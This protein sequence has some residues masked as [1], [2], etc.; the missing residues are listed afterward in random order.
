MCVTTEDV[1]VLL[2]GIMGSVLA[3][4]GKEVWGPSAG[5]ILRA[6]KSRGESVRELEL[7]GDDPNLDTLGDGVTATRLVPDV[8]L[9]PGFWKIDGYSTTAD[10]LVKNLRLVK[11]RNFFEFPYDWRR[12]LAPAA[13]QL[14]RNVNDWLAGRKQAGAKDPKA[15]LVAHSM[16][17][18]VS[19]YFLEVLGGWQQTRTL[20]TF[21]TPYRGSLNALGY[22]A[23][24][25]K[26]A[27]FD[28]TS[29]CRT[30]T[31]LYE[32][33]PIYEC[34][35]MGGGAPTRVAET[36]GLPNVDAQCAADAL[37][38]HRKIESEQANNT[39]LAGYGYRI[40][41]LVGFDQPTNQSA[42]VDNGKLEMLQ[43]LNGKDG[44]GDGTV[45]RVSAT[46]IELSKAHAEVFAAECHGSLQNNN[47]LLEHMQ[48]TLTLPDIGTV[49]R[50]G[51]PVSI[52]VKA[53]DAYEAGRVIEIGVKTSQG[54]PEMQADLQDAVSN[55]T[56]VSGAA[57]RDGGAMGQRIRFDP[58][59]EGHYRFTIRGG[60]ASPVTDVFVVG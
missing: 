50:V 42:R 23:N 47:G 6:L 51:G 38:F 31:G 48:G 21:G 56:I 2:P 59:P 58:L 16:G 26:I 13:R 41:P 3:R 22:L 4:N 14:Q 24:G 46:P 43:T 25:Y 60:E 37:A 10:F 9:I 49:L 34:V 28:L 54:K 8:T 36:P 55:K 17:G 11:G 39:K 57:V 29:L 45:P 27:A 5:S 32:L 30:L 15:I 40:V 53:E 35:S 1:F 44:S 33:L 20:V 19:R 18:L 12:H 52:S 7:Q